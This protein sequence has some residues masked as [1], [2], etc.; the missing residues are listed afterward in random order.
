[1]RS[2]AWLLAAALSISSVAAQNAER[3]FA[4]FERITGNWEARVGTMGSLI[5][6]NLRSISNHSAVVE[7][8]TTVSGRE[9]L[10]IF[11]PDGNRL[12]ATHYCAQG[13]Q[14]RLVMDAHST[15]AEMTF[16]Y[17]DATNLKSEHDS[18]LVRLVLKIRDDD[19]FEKTEVYRERGV[20]DV[21]V[22]QFVRVR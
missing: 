5:R 3:A 22:Y 12:M 10:T 17:L 8:Y 9:T 2:G 18:H 4:G 15:P 20:E 6:V 16:R 13:N 11:H 21:T 7:T 14:P 19:H 1:M